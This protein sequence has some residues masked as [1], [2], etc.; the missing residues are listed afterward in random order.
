[1][2]YFSFR[3]FHEVKGYI[4]DYLSQLEKKAFLSEDKTELYMLVI[5]CLEVSFLSVTPLCVFWKLSETRGSHNGILL[6][7]IYRI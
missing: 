5:S 3:S 7:K 2:Y 4:Q 1:M 6:L